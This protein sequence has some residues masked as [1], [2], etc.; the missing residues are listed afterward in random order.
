MI[1]CKA[2]LKKRKLL[3]GFSQD[4]A[5]KLSIETRAGHVCINL[6]NTFFLLLNNIYFL[7]YLILLWGLFLFS[8]FFFEEIETFTSFLHQ[9]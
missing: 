6:L 5:F 9:I 3:N 2:F 4:K 1:G 7:F 8:C